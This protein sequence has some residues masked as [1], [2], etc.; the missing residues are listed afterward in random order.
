MYILHDYYLGTSL[1]IRLWRDCDLF[2][3]VNRP[4]NIFAVAANS[5]FV[6]Q[7]CFMRL[8]NEITIYNGLNSF[9]YI[10][11]VC[12]CLYYAGLLDKGKLRLVK[13]SGVL[14]T[15]KSPSTNLRR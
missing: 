9:E 13:R 2:V 7:K 5:D 15:K 8:L 6:L 11:C 4:S 14:L 1:K 3:Y 12:V 10:V